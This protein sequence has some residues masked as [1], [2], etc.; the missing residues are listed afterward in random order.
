MTARNIAGMEHLRI[1]HQKM[2][3]HGLRIEKVERALVPSSPVTSLPAAPYDGQVVYYQNASM[4]TDGV[5]WTFRYNSANASSYKWELVGGSSWIDEVTTAETTT[6]TS[7]A[8]LATAGPSITVPLAGVYIIQFGSMHDY[9]VI[10]GNRT[11]RHSIDVGASA[12]ADADCAPSSHVNVLSMLQ[13]SMRNIT[14]TCAAGDAIVS[15]YRTTADTAR[16]QARHLS[17][18]PINVG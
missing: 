1:V 12:A 2:N 4:A 15:K 7:Y 11:C 14:K 8:A 5:V 13:T 18:L 3:S 17:V 9:T 6:S 10:T 16:I